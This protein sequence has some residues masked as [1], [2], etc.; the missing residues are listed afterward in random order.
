M[1][2]DVFASWTVYFFEMSTTNILP[3]GIF[4]QSA[5]AVASCP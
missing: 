5:S 1:L 2:L 4:M 3:V